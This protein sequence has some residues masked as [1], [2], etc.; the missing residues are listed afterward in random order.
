M[1]NAEHVSKL[2][3]RVPAWNKWRAAN[4]DITPDLINAC[5]PRAVLT[6]AD[7]TNAHLT[8]ANLTNAYLTRAVLTNAHLTNANLIN[9]CLPR[10]VLTGA[11]LTGADLT[12]ADLTGADLTRAVLTNAHL[13]NAD[14]TGGY[15]RNGAT[16]TRPP[17]S[18]EGFCFHLIEWS[19]GE[20]KL[21][22]RVWTL[23][24]L[25]AHFDASIDVLT[26]EGQRGA[27]LAMARAVLTQQAALG[28]VE[29][30]ESGA[31]GTR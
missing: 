4:P 5:L 1:A 10:A 15:T 28:G 26:P 24:A 31:R 18:I 30:I 12:G 21:G 14:L 17:I 2:R 25:R 13:A 29:R 27:V 11:D 7:L 16:W 6:G 3:E 23:D 20:V 8:R 19:I 22:C 9:A